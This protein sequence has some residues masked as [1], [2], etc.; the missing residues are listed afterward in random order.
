M[1]VKT[2]YNVLCIGFS[3]FGWMKQTRR[4]GS[5]SDT[6]QLIFVCHFYCTDTPG[7]C[8]LM[9]NSIKVEKLIKTKL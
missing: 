2:V 9:E 8:L 3:G 7:I 4:C 1:V 5:R 6:G